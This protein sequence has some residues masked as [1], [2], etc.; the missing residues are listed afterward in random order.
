MWYFPLFQ[1]PG[2][3]PDR[4]DFSKMMENSL[5]TTSPSSLRIL[6]CIPSGPIDLCLFSFIRWSWMWLCLHW[7]GL[8]SPS[9]HLEVQEPERCRK[10]DCQWR[11][12]QKK[13]LSTSAWSISVITSFPSSQWFFLLRELSTQEVLPSSLSGKHVYKIQPQVKT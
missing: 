13:L 6:E 1:S 9:S 5:P 2:T 3:L 4:C 11:M 10:P 7:E 8:H 12:K